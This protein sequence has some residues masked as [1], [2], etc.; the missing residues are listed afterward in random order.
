MTQIDF[1]ILRPGAM[2]NRYTL[3]CRLVEKAYH[4]GRRV[5]IH[6]GSEEEALHMDRLLWTFRDGSF[7]P[8]GPRRQADAGLTP[9]L[10][11]SD[12]DPGNEH[13]VLVNL[14]LE[15]PPFFGR[16]ERLAEILDQEPR[17]LDAGR[18]R[19]GYYRERG[20]PLRHHQVGP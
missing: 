11:E 17:V 4:Q 9:V 10:I 15:V 19:F 6:V 12:G 8:H 2:G 13:D 1:Y 7:V 16:F 5:L 18:G 14:G 3:A 20:Y